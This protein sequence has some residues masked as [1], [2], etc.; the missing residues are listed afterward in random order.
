MSFIFSKNV[1]SARIIF[2]YRLP[3]SLPVLKNKSYLYKSNIW[4]SLF[5]ADEWVGSLHRPNEKIIIACQSFLIQTEIGGKTN[6]HKMA[7]ITLCARKM[8]TALWLA[9]VVTALVSP[10]PVSSEDNGGFRCPERSN[11]SCLTSGVGYYEMVCPM[12]G[13]WDMKFYVPYLPTLGKRTFHMVTSFVFN[14]EFR[15]I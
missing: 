11:C 6:R 8:A 5:A 3:K 13:Q 1:F 9:A 14:G 12:T 2:Q 7:A 4:F 15:W 10:F